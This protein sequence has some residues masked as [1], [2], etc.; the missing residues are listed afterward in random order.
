MSKKVLFTALFATVIVFS[1]SAQKLQGD[2]EP[3]KNQEE[4][5]LVIDFSETTVNGGSFEKYMAAETKGKSESAKEDWIDDWEEKLPA[6]AFSLLTISFN[7]RISNKYFT[8]GESKKAEYTIIVKVID[9]TTG[10][11]AG[12]F[13]KPSKLRTE[14]SFVKKGEKT[15]FATV[16]YKESRNSAST[17]IPNSILRISMSFTTLGEDLSATVSRALR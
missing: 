13:S 8:L 2:L 3:L 9:I 17:M 12:P 16:E 7:D 4:V 11:F 5:N 10:S 14:V 15:P 1:V 6:E